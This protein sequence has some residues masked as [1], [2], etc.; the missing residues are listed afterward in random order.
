MAQ[1]PE[2][3][4]NTLKWVRALESGAYRQTTGV[5]CGV[6][7]VGVNKNKR[8]DTFCCLGVGSDIAVRAGAI[9]DPKIDLDGHMLYEGRDTELPVDVMEFLG[10]A[11][12]AGDYTNSE[13]CRTNLVSDNDDLQ[14]NFKQIAAIIRSKPEGLFV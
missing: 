2:Q 3:E 7:G 8:N 4:K 5:L 14:L 11:S 1:T 13:G 9:G 12:S 6:A 10:L